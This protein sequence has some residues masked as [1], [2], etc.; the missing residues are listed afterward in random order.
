MPDCRP[1]CP[2]IGPAPSLRQAVFA[3]IDPDYRVRR[4]AIPIS[5]LP[6]LAA[7]VPAV[8]RAILKRLLLQACGADRRLLSKSALLYS[9]W[10]LGRNPSRSIN[11][12]YRNVALPQSHRL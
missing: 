8:L 4:S 3:A 10:S 9:P 2:S 11:E 12:E 5:V 6:A 1:S 7:P